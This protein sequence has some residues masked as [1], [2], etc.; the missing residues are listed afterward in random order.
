MKIVM[1]KQIKTINEALTLIRINR[2]NSKKKEI[3]F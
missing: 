2:I 1:I 3:K